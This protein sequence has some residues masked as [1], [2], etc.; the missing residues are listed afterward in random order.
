MQSLKGVGP[1]VRSWGEFR[2]TLGS[3][4]PLSGLCSLGKVPKFFLFSSTWTTCNIFANNFSTFPNFFR[5]FLKLFSYLSKLFQSYFYRYIHV[6]PFFFMA[7]EG[8][9]Q[10]GG[11]LSQL[12]S[13]CVTCHTCH[14]CVTDFR[15]ILGNPVEVTHMTSPGTVYISHTKGTYFPLPRIS[16]MI[17]L[18]TILHLSWTPGG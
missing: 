10:R 1:L 3:L 12:A 14:G 5:L 8:S 16:T 13:G 9:A 15:P 4:R 18:S 7:S 2:N 17:P 6:L 11:A